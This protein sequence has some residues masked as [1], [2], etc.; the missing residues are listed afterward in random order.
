MDA[1][2]AVRCRVII[3]VVVRSQRRSAVL[4][5]DMVVVTLLLCL[6][7]RRGCLWWSTTRSARRGGR[8]HVVEIL[9]SPKVALSVLVGVKLLHLAAVPRNWNWAPAN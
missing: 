4:L 9:I 6:P 5:L 1:R 7:L 8:D 2:L 3:V